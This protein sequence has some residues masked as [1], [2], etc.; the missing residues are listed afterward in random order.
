MDGSQWQTVTSERN[1]NFQKM[2]RFD[3]KV[4]A[5]NY[6]PKHP[7]ILRMYHCSVSN[8]LDPTFGKRD[9]TLFSTTNDICKFDRCPIGITVIMP[10]IESRFFD[11]FLR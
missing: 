1:L 2:I 6:T 8:T 11:R 7:I 5:R 9:Y 10:P 4:L 3:E